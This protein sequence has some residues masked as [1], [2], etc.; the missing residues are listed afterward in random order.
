MNLEMKMKLSDGTENTADMTLKGEITE[1]ISTFMSKGF[2]A[3]LNGN[4]E[5]CDK[6]NS[7]R[8]MMVCGTDLCNTI[9]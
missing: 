1:A 6:E 7:C 4:M 9:E 3:T 8:R 5:F 2:L